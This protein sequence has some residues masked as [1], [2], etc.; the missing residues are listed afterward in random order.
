MG[1]GKGYVCSTM[2]I[3]AVKNC[4]AGRLPYLEQWNAPARPPAIR[5]K[6]TD[7]GPQMERESRT[8][9]P[10]ATGT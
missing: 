3:C 8:I 10:S 6:H 1:D 5:P 2:K 7:N 9:L 4:I